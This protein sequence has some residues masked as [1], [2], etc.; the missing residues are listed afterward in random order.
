M[1]YIFG[2]VPSRRLGL[3]LGVD[4]LPKKTC[5]MDCIYCEIGK[6][7]GRV[8][9]RDIY[10]HKEEILGELNI[11]LKNQK[12]PVD[13]ITIT[14]SGEP[15]LHKDL[16]AI[17]EGAK[18]ISEKPVVVLTNASLCW[19]DE[20]KDALCLCDL[21][22]PSLDTAS[23][24][25]FR[26][27][28][29]P[30]REIDLDRIIYGLV[31]LRKKMR[32]TMWLECLFVKGLNDSKEEILALKKAISRI[33]PHRIQLNTVV[34]PPSEDFSRPVSRKRLFEIKEVLGDKAEVIVDF[35][36]NMMEG[37]EIILESEIVDTIKRRPLSMN[38]LM[39]TFGRFKVSQ[40]ALENLLSKGIIRKT[41]VNGKAFFVAT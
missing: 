7:K 11:F 10:S 19:M 6:G 41:K 28:N 27:I 35:E 3:S 20:V 13:C 8:N 17:I 1:K 29:R 14:A 2:P 15:T 36:K 12:R 34:R 22:L 39:T 24:K 40:R 21:V 30:H 23:E 32:G 26:K 5:N 9:K 38:D 25:S 33:N 18:R 37:S 4:I 16:K 31:E